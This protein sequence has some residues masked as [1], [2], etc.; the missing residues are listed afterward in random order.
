MLVGLQSLQSV[1]EMMGVRACYVDNVDFRISE[2][3]VI[4]SVAG[5]LHG[6]LDFSLERVCLRLARRRCDRRNHML[7]IAGSTS[8]WI[9][10]QVDGEL[11][12]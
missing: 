8:R 6:R 7:Y 10:E 1:L 2:K 5:A 3:F 12:A 4:R 11:C 9:D